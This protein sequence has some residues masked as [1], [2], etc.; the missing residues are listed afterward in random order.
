METP[1]GYIGILVII[2]SLTK[3]PYAKPIKAKQQKK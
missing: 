2:E 3:F 1:D